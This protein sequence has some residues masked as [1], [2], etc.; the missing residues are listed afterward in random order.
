MVRVRGT[1]TRF[2]LVMMEAEKSRL[3]QDRYSTGKGKAC[4]KVVSSSHVHCNLLCIIFAQTDCSCD[5]TGNHN[6]KLTR[7]K[8]QTRT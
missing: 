8:P 3:Y 7:S 5:P 6:V 1:R 2:V 4:L